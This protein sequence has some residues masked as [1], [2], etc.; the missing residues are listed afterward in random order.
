M[1]G[2][3]SM[4]QAC[5]MLEMSDSRDAYL[6]SLCAHTLT[7]AASPDHSHPGRAEGVTSPT[8][9][10]LAG[11]WCNCRCTC[12][13]LTSERNLLGDGGGQDCVLVQARAGSTTLMQH[14][15]LARTLPAS[16]MMM[17]LQAD[18]PGKQVVDPRFRVL[19]LVETLTHRCSQLGC[20]NM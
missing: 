17:H 8:G 16:M 13:G 5:G 20:H 1:Q 6:T 10:P 7:D 4:T 2:F 15:F 3:Q 9:T 14:H 19:V 18:T 11:L 12:K